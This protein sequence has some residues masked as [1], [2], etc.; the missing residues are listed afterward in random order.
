MSPYFD[1]SAPSR[2]LELPML[3]A[4]SRYTY[5]AP[6][7]AMTASAQTATSRV[8]AMRN[9]RGRGWRGRRAGWLVFLRCALMP[10]DAGGGVLKES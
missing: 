4:R 7:A 6:A 8:R 5:Q 10:V 9:R 3:P 1:F 2:A